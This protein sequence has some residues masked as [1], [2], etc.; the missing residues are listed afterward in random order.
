MAYPNDVALRLM[1][2]KQHCKYCAHWKQLS[3]SAGAD[4]SCDHD[5]VNFIYMSPYQGRGCAYFTPSC[6]AQ[7]NSNHG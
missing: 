1:G 6:K 2:I 3:H 5:L 4:G 7:E